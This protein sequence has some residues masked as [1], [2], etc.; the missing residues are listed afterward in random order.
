[1]F[2]RFFSKNSNEEY[3]FRTNGILIVARNDIL[4]T[5]DNFQPSGVNN[6][7]NQGGVLLG[8]GGSRVVVSRDP[9]EI[10]QQAEHRAAQG[11]N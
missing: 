11:R 3:V 2:F 6:G 9:P 5:Q 4:D 8:P 7:W 1:M 10:G